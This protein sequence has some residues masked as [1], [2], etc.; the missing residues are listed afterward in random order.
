MWDE[1]MKNTDVNKELAVLEMERTMVKHSIEGAK[2][3]MANMLLGGMG[4]D[5][6][7]VLTGKKVI[8]VKKRNIFGKMLDAFDTLLRKTN[9]G[10][11]NGVYA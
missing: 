10:N 3:E 6:E 11:D 9:G 2:N 8:K 5:M 4:Q 1:D 7:D